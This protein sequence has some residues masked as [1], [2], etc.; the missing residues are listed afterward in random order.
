MATASASSLDAY[1]DEADRFIAALDE[2]YYLHYSGLKEAFELEPIYERFA[3]LTTLDAAKTLAGHAESGGSGEVELWHFACEGY[4]G[5]FVSEE[6]EKVAEAETKTVKVGDD[7]IPYRDLRARMHANARQLRAGLEGAGF[8]LRP[9]EHPILPVMLGDAALA[10][11]MADRLLERGIF[12]IGFSYPVVP[13]GQARIRIQ[14]SAAHTP[15]QLARA[16][17][18]FAEV[19]KELGVI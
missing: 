17:R 4:L 13:Q 6:E 14:V 18:A 7:E 12:V 10:G 8:R 15:E 1:R 11:E 5:N 19:G 2:E 3:E 9:G 16:V